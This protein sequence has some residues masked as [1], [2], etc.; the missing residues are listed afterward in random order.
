MFDR[1]SHRDRAGGEELLGDPV[2]AERLRA[3][4]LEQASRFTWC[5]TARATLRSYELALA[6]A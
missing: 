2:A 3:A 1:E 5:A 6:S 4:G